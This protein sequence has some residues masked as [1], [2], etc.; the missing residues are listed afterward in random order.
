MIPV[1]LLLTLIAFLLLHVMPGDPV[2]T[3][4]GSEATPEAITSLRHELGLDKPIYVQYFDWLW[5]V[6]Q[7]DFGRSIRT[8]IPV[9][10]LIAERLPA[11]LQ[12]GLSA[13]ILSL[14]IAVSIGIL[15]GIRR[16]SKLDQVGRVFAILGIAVPN[17]FLG[18]VLIL[19][20][21]VALRWLPPSG[22]VSLSQDF[23]RSLKLT[24][25]P[26]ITLAAAM[27]AVTMRQL[28]SSLLEVLEQDFIRTAR[29]KGLSE[30]IVIGRHAMKN[31]LIPVVTILAIQVAILFGGS[32]IVETIFAIP[33]VGRL[34][35]N[36]ILAQDFPIVQA[37]VLLIG[38]IVCL[39]NLIADLSYAFLDPRIRYS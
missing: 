27:G 28:R 30:R 24:I 25:L 34:A 21:A 4:L 37:V 18:V 3:I 39:F 31:A 15:S 17:F 7:G 2:I 35:V 16:N 1:L 5:R 13:M 38:V 8:H 10:E 32:V 26:A 6:V 20:F 29:A 19:I 9:S 14:L 12:I 22:Y 23:F 11:T 33:G 36:A